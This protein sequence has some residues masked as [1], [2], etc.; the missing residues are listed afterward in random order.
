MQEICSDDYFFDQE[1]DGNIANTVTRR[2]LSL[3]HVQ[4]IKLMQ[5][6]RPT[7]AQPRR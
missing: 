2:L 1:K 4:I 3:S 7:K 6:R 5:K